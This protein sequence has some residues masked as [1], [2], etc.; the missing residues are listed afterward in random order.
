MIDFG[1]LCK[2]VS[3]RRPGLLKLSYIFHKDWFDA[4]SFLPASLRWRERGC[5]QWVA[6]QRDLLIGRRGKIF[7]SS[8]LKPVT[9]SATWLRQDVWTDII[10]SRLCTVL[11]R[12]HSL[13]LA[14]P[15]LPSILPPMIFCC[16]S[17][18]CQEPSFPFTGLWHVAELERSSFQQATGTRLV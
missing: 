2:C 7:V 6:C 10:P 8:R 3:F 13:A 15:R 9:V 18:N 4:F 5:L 14:S 11:H 16:A 17:S 1:H 12:A